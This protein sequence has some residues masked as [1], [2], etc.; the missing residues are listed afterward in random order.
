R[1]V[2]RL[3]NQNLVARLGKAVSN[4][5]ALS[6]AD[7]T[8]P[9]FALTA[10]TGQALG[11]IRLDDL[12]DSRRQVAETT[13]TANSPLRSQTVGAASATWKLQV[14][15]HL[16]AGGTPRFLLD[17]DP[18]QELIAD[19]RL[20]I[21]GSPHELAPLLEEGPAGLANVRWAGWFRR[22]GRVVWRT[23]TEVEI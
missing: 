12:E 21:C 5:H 13:V 9:L 23:L 2:M 11:T 22:L 14:I 10:L 1:V 17:V 3:F 19:D 16:P 18:E 15:A 7:L 20:I 6:T 8:A 4:V